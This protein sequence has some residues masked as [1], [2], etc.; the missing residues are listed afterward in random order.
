M[1]WMK[2]EVSREGWSLEGGNDKSSTCA[3]IKIYGGQG[4]IGKGTV[5]SK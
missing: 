1:S 2:T 4:N 5:L 3:G